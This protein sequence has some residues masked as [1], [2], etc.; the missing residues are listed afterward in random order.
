MPI[1][2]ETLR[3]HD[4][5]VVRL[6]VDLVDGVTAADLARPTPC[7]GWDL[8]DLL[9]HLATQHRGFAAAVEGRGDDPAVWTVTPIG[10]DPAAE[11][12]QAADLVLKAF[13]AVDDPDRP[14]SLPEISP[15]DSL[16][17]VV[18]IG[19]HAV[20]YLIHSWDVA[21]SLGRPFRP[22][23]NVTAALLPLVRS[24]PDDERRT[25]PGRAFAPGL[26]PVEGESPGDRILR[27]VGR[28]PGW[29]P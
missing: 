28:S 4:A 14:C 20:D 3:D 29:R 8:G 24:I 6:S 25:E 15:D 23:E 2:L 5:S 26:P 22:D 9:A 13:S 7:A 1:N 10:N 11:Y 16:P 12:R 18:T 21:A 19:I 17:A 27:L